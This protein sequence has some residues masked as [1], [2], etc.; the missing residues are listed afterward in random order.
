MTNR[1]HFIQGA[2]A[3]IGVLAGAIFAGSTPA[4]AAEPIRIG[5][6]T[7]YNSFAAFNGPYRNGWQMALEEI[8]AA[9]GVMGRQLEIIS[10]D[11]GGTTGDA[12]RVAEELVT[13]EKAEFIFG[14]FL[15]NIG[16]AVS[17]YANQN[18]VL[19]IAAEPLTDALTIEKGN[20]YTFR[21][22]PNTHM[23]TAM[24]VQAAKDSGIKKWAIVVP[25][26][27][28]GQSAAANFKRMIAE[29]IPGA[30]IVAEQYPALGKIDAGAT[31]AAIDQAGP[32]GIFT[33]L[34]GGD[35]IK[36][37]REGNTRGLFENKQVL[38]LLTGEP[39]WLK[40]LKD[41]APEGWLVT[42]YPW[43]QI[44]D[45]AHQTFVANYRAKYNDTPRLGSLL[46]Y[47]IVYTIK[48]AIETAGS[49]E[50]EA[51]ITALE[52]L[53]VDTVIGPITMRAIDHQS[54]MGAWVGRLTVKD[55]EG[56]M[57][58][59]TYQD[60]TPFMT[61]EAEIRERRPQ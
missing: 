55:G 57:V 35:L 4:A 38:S 19:F 51:M 12:V 34:F 32:T 18:K 37:V 53:Q 44:E 45:E 9:G 60:G 22:R 39:E 29:Q 11:D 42:G 16:L 54:S 46:G 21:M 47:T 56:A 40:V 33:A 23:Q 31:V 61:P 27:A 17:D 2:F 7:S 1:R 8:N 3:A 25:N 15:S 20:R 48:K 5:E 14:T 6:L 59:W 41:E 26:Y 13:R 58:D 30:E 52:G 49:T 36:F 24:L 28:Y 50:T 43:E 10:R